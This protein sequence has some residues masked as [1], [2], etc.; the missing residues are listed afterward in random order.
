MSHRTGQ[1]VWLEER[2]RGKTKYTRE[3]GPYELMFNQRF[4]SLIEARRAEKWI[5]LQKSR[6]LIVN[7]I[8]NGILRKNFSV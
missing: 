3:T 8:T 1:G 2:N 6:Q 7:I 4:K 5:K